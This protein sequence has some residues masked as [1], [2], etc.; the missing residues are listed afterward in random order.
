MS[1][2]E[3]LF[4]LSEV[5]KTEDFSTAKAWTLHHAIRFE[6]IRRDDGPTSWAGVCNNAHC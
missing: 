2:E 3:L 6:F 4:L 1:G 5:I